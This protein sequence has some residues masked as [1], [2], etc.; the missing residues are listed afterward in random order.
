MSLEPKRPTQAV[1]FAGGRGERLR[2]LTDTRPKAMIEFHG[3][4]FLQ[5]LLQMIRSQGIERALLLLGYLPDVVIDY[6]GDGRDLGIDIAYST[7]APDDLTA[8]RLQQA[9]G[10]L[11]PHFLLMYCDNYWAM[12]FDAMWRQ[13]LDADRPVQV[14]VYANSDGASRSNVRV[15]DDGAVEAFDRTRSAPGLQGVEIG[16]AIVNK[17][18]AFELLPDHQVL[19]EDAV[20]P[21]LVARRALQAFVTH[22]RYYSVGD[23]D[24]MAA[25]GSFLESVNT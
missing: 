12:P 19:F 22:D 2:P 4:P 25:T 8:Y 17:H 21:P 6:F 1:V 15:G 20:Y 3:K 5:Y 11:D 14:T 24:R 16:Y 10:L 7:T 23:H 13:Y 9:E 18:A